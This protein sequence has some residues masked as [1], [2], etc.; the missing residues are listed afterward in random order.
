MRVAMEFGVN[1]LSL[2]F[3]TLAMET[4]KYGGGISFF[5]VGGVFMGF[6]NFFVKPIIKIFSLP[7]I[8]LTGGLFLIVINAVLLWLFAQF[9]IIVQINGA[10]IAFP[11]FLSYLLGAVIFG[12][13]N[14]VF[15]LL[16]K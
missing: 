9:L 3:L 12:V 15:H 6:L 16:I 14:W 10:F 11:D 13:L 4:V 7:F 1:A 5:I 8:F 2:Y